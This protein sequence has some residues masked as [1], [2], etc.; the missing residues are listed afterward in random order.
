MQAFYATFW[1]RFNCDGFAAASQYSYVRIVSTKLA[2]VRRLRLWGFR[3]NSPND[4]V[5]ARTLQAVT[6]PCMPFADISS[7]TLAERQWHR[8][9]RRSSIEDS[10][11][12]LI[13]N[14]ST[15]YTYVRGLNA[16]EL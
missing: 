5:G 11:I 14:P 6:L 8:F 7:H 10:R 12:T 3:L 1:E 16:L 15:V 13:F 2:P 9:E 4:L